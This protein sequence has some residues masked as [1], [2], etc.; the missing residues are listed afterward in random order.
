[1]LVSSMIEST[2]RLHSLTLPPVSQV[3]IEI[4]LDV[5]H[6]DQPTLLRDF[7]PNFPF[8]AESQEGKM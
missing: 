4:S 6:K 2:R 8:Y 5:L 3:E 7:S 1:M